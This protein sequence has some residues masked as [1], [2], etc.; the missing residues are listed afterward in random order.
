MPMCIQSCLQM[1]PDER[2]TCQQLLQHPYMDRNMELVNDSMRSKP[3]ARTSSYAQVSSI[4]MT[5]E[6][7]K[8]LFSSISFILPCVYASPCLCITIV[9]IAVYLFHHVCMTMFIFHCVYA[10]SWLCS[11][12]FIFHRVELHHVCVTTCVYS[13]VTVFYHVCIN[14]SIFH[15]VCVSP[16]LCNTISIFHCVLLYSAMYVYRHVHIPLCLCFTMSR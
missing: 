15:C 13:S 4:A 14:M 2:L 11:T 8:P 16:C 12:M 5:R 1:D 10:L 7:V 3:K 6:P 9:Y